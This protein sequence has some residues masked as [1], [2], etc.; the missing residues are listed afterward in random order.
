MSMALPNMGKIKEKLSG[1]MQYIK[2]P[3]ERWIVHFMQFLIILTL[4]LWGGV[5]YFL[6]QKM[7]HPEKHVAHNEHEPHFDTDKEVNL[8]ESH[9]P[10]DILDRQDGVEASGHDLSET[11]NDERGLASIVDLSGEVTV[12]VGYLFYELSKLSA[13]LK[14]E[15]NNIEA[16]VEA[17]I[18]FQ[19]EDR[20]T[21]AE[22]EGRRIELKAMLEGIMGEFNKAELLT[23]KGK[24]NLK[25]NIMAQMNFRLKTGHVVDVLFSNFR[26]Q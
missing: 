9:I 14:R 23:L 12:D 25:Q 16:I 22:I 21:K 18:S 19:V 6:Y 17:D 1:L 8:G 24:N 26:I 4:S 10:K 13:G 11:A 3:R 20:A 5:S 15:D 7:F 2:P